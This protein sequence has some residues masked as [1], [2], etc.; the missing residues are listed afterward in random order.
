[1]RYTDNRAQEI[2]F[3]VR[4]ELGYKY[5]EIVF[6]IAECVDIIGEE[7]GSPENATRAN[8]DR[9]C[10]NVCDDNV[11]D[12]WHIFRFYCESPLDGDFQ[13]AW[14]AF[15]DDVVRITFYWYEDIEEI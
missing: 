12:L 5:D 9:V 8:C 15:M 13:E 7:L 1:M 6:I 11:D 10:H 4:E 2:A 14:G 3:F